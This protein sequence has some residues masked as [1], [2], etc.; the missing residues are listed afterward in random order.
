MVL[1]ILQMYENKLNNGQMEG[2][3]FLRLIVN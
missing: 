2:R 1:N 3:M